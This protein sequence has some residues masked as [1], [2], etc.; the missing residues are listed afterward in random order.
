MARVLCVLCVFLAACDGASEPTADEQPATAAGVTG[1][2]AF[3]HALGTPGPIRLMTARGGRPTR[4]GPAGDIVWALS[5]SPDGRRV[6]YIASNA[7]G[8]RSVRVLA[9]RSGRPRVLLAAPRRPSPLSELWFQVAWDPTGERIAVL[10]GSPGDPADAHVDV[11]DLHGRV[12]AAGLAPDASSNSRLAWSPDGRKLVY[13]R[14]TADPTTAFGK[15]MVVAISSRRR[16]GLAV[17]IAGS[18]PAW[19]P[20]GS[21]IAFATAEGIAVARSSGGG[22]RRLTRG[23]TSDKTPT[24]SPDGRWV[25]YARQTGACDT[26]QARCR[27]DLFRVAVGGGTAERIRRTPDLFEVNPVWGP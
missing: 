7:T 4:V 5:W 26:P 24:W 27:Q 15:L 14:Q 16:R 19:S 21:R 2:L 23:G 9:A 6:A 8:P 12:R 25:A 17:H 1:R 13:R 3:H 11:V 22:Y 18:D 10:R 20:D